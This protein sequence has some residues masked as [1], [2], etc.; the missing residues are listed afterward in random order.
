MSDSDLTPPAGVPEWA[1]ALTSVRKDLAERIERVAAT[2][3]VAH[4]L[5]QQNSNRLLVLVGEDGRNGKMS[6]VFADL[7]DHES[8]IRD[9][10]RFIVKNDKAISTLAVKLALIASIFATIGAIVGSALA[11]RIHFGG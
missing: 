9:N 5:G 1:T 7:G 11:G 10:E 6:E 2:A 8:R 4:G 3:D